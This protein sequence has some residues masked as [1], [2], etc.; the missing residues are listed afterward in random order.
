MDNINDKPRAI[1]FLALTTEFKIPKKGA[2]S[3]KKGQKIS[4]GF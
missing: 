4:K 2:S 3:N 1:H